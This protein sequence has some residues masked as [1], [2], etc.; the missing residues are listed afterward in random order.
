MGL[1]NEIHPFLVT[2]NAG[3]QYKVPYSLRFRAASS[4]YLSRTPRIAGDRKTWTWSGW[5][6]RSETS[7]SG[8]FSSGSS[9]GTPTYT[10]TLLQFDSS[11]R[12][13]FLNESYISPS[14]T[15]TAECYTTAVFRDQSAWYHIVCVV[16][17]TA[18]TGSNRIKIYVNGVQQTLTFSTTPA[19][20]ASFY[21]NDIK[22]HVIGT[23]WN[24]GSLPSLEMMDAYLAEVQFVDGQALDPSYFGQ[25]DSITGM[26]VP[27]RYQGLEFIPYTATAGM[28]TQSGLAAFTAAN[29][30]A[31][32]DNAALPG[33]A[34][35]TDTA[36]AGS[37]LQFDLGVGNA[38][39]FR[40]VRV[41]TDKSSGQGAIA[42]WNIQYSDDGT[43]WTTAYTS[44]DIVTNN[45]SYG[46]TDVIP[47]LAIWGSTGSHRYWR[48]YKTNSATGGDY[49]R[50]VTFYTAKSSYLPD[51]GTNGFY[52]PFS[53]L[54]T[55]TFGNSITYSQNLENASWTKER[56]TIGTNYFM[57]PDGTP[58]ADKLI[59]DTTASSTHRTYVQSGAL[60]NGTTYCWSVYAKAGERSAFALEAWN[61]STAKYA[62]VDLSAGT[63][64]SG[65]D[66]NATVTAV[67]NGWYKCSV[68]HV[69][70]AGSTASSLALY[71]MNSATAGAMT[72]TGDGTSGIYFWG[73]QCEATNAGVPGPYIS[74]SGSATST[75]YPVSVDESKY[76][77]NVNK[78]YNNFASVAIQISSTPTTSTTTH[79]SYKDTPTSYDDG[80]TYYNRGNYCTLNPLTKLLS[81]YTL[82][83]GNLDITNPTVG[84]VGCS[85][86]ISVSSGKWY[87]EVYIG[88][89]PNG[90]Y[91]GI[92]ANE[93]YSRYLYMQTGNKYSDSGGSVAYAASFTTGDIISVAFDLDNGNVV[94]YKN[95]ASQGTA[96][97]GISGT[98]TP[99]WV[100]NGQ[101]ST[102]SNYNFG[103]R[104]FSYTPPAGFKAMNSYNLAQPS[105]PLV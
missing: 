73:G 29:V 31:D 46:S 24:S 65:S 96:F 90:T 8:L 5:V 101:A 89:V 32:A 68:T 25:T 2:G 27:K 88:S 86:T 74:T 55:Q 98:F 41:I 64:I 1:P 54:S 18:G 100:T 80:S 70:V 37:Y 57:A 11:D 38:Q 76:N 4:A 19:Q 43:N 56:A 22:Q 3:N 85:G 60:T 62:Y 104:P 95:G 49:H 53:N 75:Y 72:Y 28:V 44:L 78:S 82:A 40:K 83:A 61:N 10:E 102:A 12:L 21:I 67:D 26:W 47:T 97:T 45:G 93:Q 17:T 71:L 35:H 99:V 77:K 91:F 42:V 36:A 20:Y 50:R 9:G 15:I 7:R 13:Y 6:K 14:W 59:E 16:D 94:F 63:V 51:Y 23:N 39:E 84:S 87:F 92:G 48:L 69:G 103:Q 30:V 105:L 66:T 33:A 81:G 34:F 79:D 58:T 52:L